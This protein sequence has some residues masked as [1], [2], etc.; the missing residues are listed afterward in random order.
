[1]VDL[2]TDASGSFGCG[3]WWQEATTRMARGPGNLV[4]CK[5]GAY[6]GSGGVYVMGHQVVEESGQGAL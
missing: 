4:N 2:C 5:E 6:T 3:V 1:M